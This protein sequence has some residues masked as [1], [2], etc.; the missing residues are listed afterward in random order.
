M[1]G[2]VIPHYKDTEALYKCIKALDSQDL[3]YR[4]YVRDNSE[5]NIYFTKAINEGIREFKYYE[6]YILILNQDCYIRKGSLKRM[7]EFMDSNENCGMCSPITVDSN[8]NVT[9][10]GGKSAF[11]EGQHFHEILSEKPYKTHWLNGACMFIRTNMIEEIGLFDE[12]MEF[13]CS[14]SDYSYTA[15]SRGWSLYM[16]PDAFA[17]HELHGSVST[18]SKLLDRKMKD[19]LYFQKKWWNSQLF[20]NLDYSHTEYCR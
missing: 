18:E 17:E 19:I 20:F 7:V 4:L 13:I 3:K 9:F 10:A 11:P 2:V 6:K 15:R 8:E 14:D 16:I 5:D 12:N 1:I